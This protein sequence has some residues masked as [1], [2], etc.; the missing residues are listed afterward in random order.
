[1]MN[2]LTVADYPY[3]VSPLGEVYR[4]GSVRPLKQFPAVCGGYMQVNLWKDNKGKTHFVHQIVAVAF[5]GP[6][7]SPRHH[8]AHRDGDKKNNTPTNVQWITKEENEADKIRH[9]TTNR[10]E[11]NGSA[12]VSNAQATEMIE[13]AK[14]LPLSSG[15]KRLKKGALAQ[16]AAQYGVTASGAWQIINGYR[17]NA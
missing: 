12:K 5:H 1:M 17:R 11:R 9:G 6:R 16:L 2:N 7:P 4:I 8:A 14:S 3:E 13:L 10:G 15:G